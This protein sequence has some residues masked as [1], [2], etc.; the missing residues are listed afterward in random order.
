MTSG[1]YEIKQDEVKPPA[2]GE[3]HIT[4]ECFVVVDDCSENNSENF[5]KEL[6]ALLNKYAI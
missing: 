3:R 2:W 1:E 6:E 5:Y 4:V